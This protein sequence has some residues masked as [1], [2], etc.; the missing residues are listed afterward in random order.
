MVLE[1]QR[2]H[3]RVGDDDLEPLGLVQQGVDPRARAV[4]AEIAADAVAQHARLA[5][6]QRVA[7]VVEV[8]VDAGLL[9]KAGDLGLEITDRHALHC[10]V[11]AR[12]L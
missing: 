5:H 1:R 11:L 3:D 2:L 7:R 6:V 8:Q 9:G 4:G 10:R 12:V